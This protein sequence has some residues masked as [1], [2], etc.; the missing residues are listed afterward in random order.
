MTLEITAVESHALRAV[1]EWFLP[2][3][4][5]YPSLN[6]AD[7][8]GHVLVLVLRQLTPLRDEITAALGAVPIDGVAE[9][10]TDLR[11]CNEEQFTLLR[12]LCLGWYLT[13]RPVWTALGYTGRVPTP[14]AS[15]DAD[16]DLRDDILEPVRRRG[17]VFRE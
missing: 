16:H 9:H 14:I 12:T 3:L 7:P 13:C 10:M 1:S 5:G 15:G 8:E 2:S 11:D 17:S 6:D 4:E